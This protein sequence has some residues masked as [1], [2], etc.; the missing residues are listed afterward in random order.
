VAPPF[1]ETR[2]PGTGRGC[3]QVARRV[4]GGSISVTHRASV[5]PYLTCDI[6]YVTEGPSEN[7]TDL[8]H[9]VVYHVCNRVNGRGV[10][11]YRFTV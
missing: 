4:K 2:L 1:R 5:G 11:T 9:L 3:E 8:A 7:S 6:A 10:N